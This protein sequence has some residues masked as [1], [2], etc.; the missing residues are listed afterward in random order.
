MTDLPESTIMSLC[1][2][3]LRAKMAPSCSMLELGSGISAAARP[4]TETRPSSR[5]AGTAHPCP[6]VFA[7]NRARASVPCHVR[8]TGE[9][10]DV[11]PFLDIFVSLPFPRR[12]ERRRRGCQRTTLHPGTPPPGPPSPR[13]PPRIPGDSGLAT[14]S[15]PSPV[16]P[17]ARI[18]RNPALL[19]NVASDSR[20]FCTMWYQL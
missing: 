16:P 6:C 13:P 14:P 1:V 11:Q 2:K 15:S 3:P 20:A 7:R 9:T 4:A 10:E 17:A 19:I 5:P 12:R 18:H 8:E